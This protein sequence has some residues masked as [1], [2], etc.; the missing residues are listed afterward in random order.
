MSTLTYADQSLVGV[1]AENAKPARKPL[2]TRLYN[3]IVE[4]RQRRAQ[5]EIADFLAGRP[6]TDDVERELMRRLSG[7]GPR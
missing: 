7:G 6:L 4:S 1:E 5:R 2:L 3:A